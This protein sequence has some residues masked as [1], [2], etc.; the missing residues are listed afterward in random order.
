[1]NFKPFE[2]NNN[3]AKQGSPKFIAILLQQIL[4]LT[5]ALTL[6]VFCLGISWQVNKSANFSYNFWYQH[7]NINKTIVKNVA[8]NIHG[9]Q[10]FPTDDALLHQ[11]K[12]SDIVK[13]IH[14]QGKGLSNI[15]YFNAKG[16]IRRFL[17]SS[18]VQHLQDVANLLDK[19]IKIWWGSAL[20]LLVLFVVYHNASLSKSNANSK[21]SSFNRLVLAGMSIRAI[22]KIPSGKQKS[23]SVLILLLLSIT[24]LSIWGFT[25]VFYYL[26]TVVFPADHQWFFYYYDSLMS[27]IMK[28]PDIF[29][30][31][32]G[33]LV[34]L[35]ICLVIII[36]V[37]VTRFIRRH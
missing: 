19:V 13:A 20:L 7:L 5:W 22:T 35:G 4:W 36:D 18:E 33:Q 17:T 25:S 31:I 29:A 26:H 10:D 1:M 3:N 21:L 15:S 16:H 32:A 11:E 30:A 28:A 2:V 34:L 37:M 14:Q 12:F 8:K 9:K 23:I 6:I 27:T 24:V